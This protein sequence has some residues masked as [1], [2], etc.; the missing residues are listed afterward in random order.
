LPKV[1]TSHLAIIVCGWQLLM[2]GWA[3]AGRDGRADSQD[4]H[5]LP[6]SAGH[7]SLMRSLLDNRICHATFA[8]MWRCGDVASAAVAMLLLLHS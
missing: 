3:G 7:A 1:A 8:A 4:E 5:R 2:R 6:A